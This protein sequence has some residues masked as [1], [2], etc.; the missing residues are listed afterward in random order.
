FNDLRGRGTAAL[1]L[2]VAL[3]TVASAVVPER[4]AAAGAWAQSARAGVRAESNAAGAFESAGL[5]PVAN[6]FAVERDTTKVLKVGPATARVGGV[7][8]DDS[9]ATSKDIRALVDADTGGGT[10][11]A[12]L[13]FVSRGVSPSDYRPQQPSFFSAPD[14][15]QVIAQY[16]DD[17]ADVDVR[18]KIVVLQR[19]MGVANNRFRVIGPDVGLAIQ[20]ALKRGAAAVL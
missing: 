9:A 7:T 2:G 12:P 8:L 3:V 20:N 4:Y 17:Y 6:A 19:F 16:A 11:D 5:R 13:V 1:V 18:G 15:G 10:V 14:L